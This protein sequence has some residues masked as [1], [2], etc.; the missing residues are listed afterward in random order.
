M[1]EHKTHNHMLADEIEFCTA[2]CGEVRQGKICTEPQSDPHVCPYKEIVQRDTETLCR[3]CSK[4]E[5]LCAM[6]T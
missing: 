2:V 1:D 5:H 6:E 3:C 4:C